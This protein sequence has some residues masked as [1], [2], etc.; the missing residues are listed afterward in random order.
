MSHFY[1]FV[2]GSSEKIVAR[3]GT[4]LSGMH[5]QVQS[6]DVGIQV[7]AYYNEKKKRNEF[8]VYLTG[9]GNNPVKKKLVFSYKEGDK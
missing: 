8:E 5:A 1:G 4:I 2:K 3:T 7:D 6:W 9:G